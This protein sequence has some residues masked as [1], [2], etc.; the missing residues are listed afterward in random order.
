M[1]KTRKRAR[2]AARPESS[3]AES[4]PVANAASPVHELPSDLR[5]S[6]CAAERSALLAAMG[7]HAVFVLDAS[8]VKRVD[9]TGLQ[10]LVAACRHQRQRGGGVRWLAVSGPLSAAATLSGLADALCLAS[11]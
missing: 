6:V 9:A 8:A 7:E 5:I 4:P 3:Q 2:A 11:S 1:A 10:L